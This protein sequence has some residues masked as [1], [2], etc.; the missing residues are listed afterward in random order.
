MIGSFRAGR[1]EYDSDRIVR[2]LKGRGQ[3]SLWKKQDSSLYLRWKDTKTGKIVTEFRLKPNECSYAQVHGHSR[4]Y[5]F[6]THNREDTEGAEESSVHSVNVQNASKNRKTPRFFFF[7]SQEPKDSDLPAEFCFTLH[8][9]LGKVKDPS[10]DQLTS[11]GIFR[12]IEGGNIVELDLRNLDRDGNPFKQIF[13]GNSS[14][15]SVS[16][17]MSLG[18]LLAGSSAKSSSNPRGLFGNSKGSGS[19]PIGISS[20]TNPEDRRAVLKRLIP[21]LFGGN[22]GESSNSSKNEESLS[23]SSDLFE[24]G[25]DESPT[26]SP[27]GSHSGRSTL[28]RPRSFSSGAMTSRSPF[29]YRIDRD[30]FQ[31]PE[32]INPSNN[33]T[34]IHDPPRSTKRQGRFTTLNRSIRTEEEEEELELEGPISRKEEEEEDDFDTFRR[35]IDTRIQPVR[36]VTSRSSTSD[37][38]SSLS[39]ISPITTKKKR[40]RM[41]KEEE[42]DPSSRSVLITTSS[43]L[44]KLLMMDEEEDSSESET[45]SEVGRDITLTASALAHVTTASKERLLLEEPEESTKIQ[46]STGSGGTRSSLTSSAEESPRPTTTTTGS[47]EEINKDGPSSSSSP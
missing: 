10:P 23:S 19:N 38:I 15:A 43:H 40:W 8:H 34:M 12:G 3:L 31:Q 17:G 1:T 4:V 28:R 6:T 35:M 47:N 42:E 30:P 18:K 5:L 25:R 24:E 44:G 11:H 45:E 32:H 7:W 21:L 2:P 27:I 46:I 29:R 41:G 9:H 26:S 16:L 20:L 36:K 39:S 33:N 14:I 13:G 37:G 22:H